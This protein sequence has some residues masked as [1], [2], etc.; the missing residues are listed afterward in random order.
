MAQVNSCG[1]R[2]P[3]EKVS[4]PCR[5]GEVNSHL[6]KVPQFLGFSEQI[7]AWRAGPL[8][9]CWRDGE[10]S[11]SRYLIGPKLQGGGSVD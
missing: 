11:N 5:L 4:A 9:A 2:P 1:E 3:L 6:T 8:Q 7:R 10:D